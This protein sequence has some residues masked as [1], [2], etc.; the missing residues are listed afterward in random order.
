MLWCLATSTG[1]GPAVRAL[2]AQSTAQGTVQDTTRAA[3]ADSVRPAQAVHLPKHLSMRAVGA[4]RAATWTQLLGMPHEWPRTWRGYGARLGDQ[5]GFAVAEESLRAG[6]RAV[7]PWRDLTGP[8]ASTE[9]TRA[10]GARSL[11]AAR[12]GVVRTFVAQNAAGDR[13]VHVPQLGAIV[14]ATALSLA[15]RPER[16][17]ARTGRRFLLTR[18]GITTGATVM[19]RAVQGWR[20]QAGAPPRRQG[21]PPSK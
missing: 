17:R 4:L 7:V 8:C 11:A 12:C 15:W 1:A 3:P 5:A 6:L 2:G 16:S 21:R 14:G 19:A 18:A 20:G 9:P 13:R 10:W